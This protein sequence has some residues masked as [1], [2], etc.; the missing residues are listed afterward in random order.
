MLIVILGT[1]A[2][3]KTDL[4]I[5]LARKFNCE[6]VLADSRQI[7]KQMD[8]GAAKPNKKERR[9]VPHHLLD[10]IAPNK[11]FSVADY[12]K[13]AY[14]AI[15]DILKKGKIPFL[16]GGTAFYIYSIVEGWQFPKMQKNEKLRK[17]LEKQPLASLLKMLKKL[18]IARF[19]TIDQKNKRRVIRA[20]EIAKEMGNVPKIKK[21]PKYDCLLLG[22][23]PANALLKQKINQR[24]DLM[25]RQGLER[26]VKNLVKKYGWTSVLKNTIGYSEWK[27][28]SAFPMERRSAPFQIKGNTWKYAKRQMT[29]FK[30]DKR[31]IWLKNA[32]QAQKEIK[33]FLNS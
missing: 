1:T 24:V 10:I 9:V 27:A 17:T 15:D 16:V 21:Q 33:L 5:K 26:E 29:W 2:S 18:D 22:L 28:P 12:Q 6:I 20:I 30:R 3:G 11:K 32:K 31:I 8:I 19:E 14:K 13:S 4:A 23:K 7:Y 25:I